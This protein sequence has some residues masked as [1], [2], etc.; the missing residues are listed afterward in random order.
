MLE[1][2]LGVLVVGIGTAYRND[3]SAGLIAAE[4]LRELSL[5]GA[6]IIEHESEGVALL[7][8]MAGW[9]CVILIDATSSGAPGGT[10]QRLDA[11]AAPVPAQMFRHST[12]AFGLA[13]AIELGRALDRLPPRLVV[14]GI[15]GRDFAAGTRLSDEVEARLPELI[16]RVVEEV[17]SLRRYSG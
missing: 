10:L 16:E 11:R 6:S 3:D 5:P 17:R 4:R 12:H 1:Q 14:Y 8:F 7:D 13:S 2:D 9:Q 15:E